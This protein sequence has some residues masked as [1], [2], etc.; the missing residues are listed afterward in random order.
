MKNRRPHPSGQGRRAVNSGSTIYFNNSI[1]LTSV[2]PSL[3][4]R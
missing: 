4:S 3:L 2:P 1:F